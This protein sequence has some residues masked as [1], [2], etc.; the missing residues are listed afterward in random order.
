VLWLR[1]R[2]DLWITLLRDCNIEGIIFIY[3]IMVKFV[4]EHVAWSEIHNPP[5][6]NLKVF[7]YSSM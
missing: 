1:R 2:K 7:A 4:D 6:Y 3:N 5:A